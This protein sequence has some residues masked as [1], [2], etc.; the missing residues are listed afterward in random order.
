[1]KKFMASNR[2]VENPNKTTLLIMNNKEEEEVKVKVG[3]LLITQDRTS[4]LL[5]I[6]IDDDMGW[7]SHVYRKGALLPSL[8]QRTHLNRRLRNHIGVDKLRKVADS[9]WASKL[10]YGFQQWTLVRL[11]DTQQ[12]TKQGTDIQKAQ[13]KLLRVMEKKKISD[14]IPVRTMLENQKI[15]SVNQTA[16]Q[17]ILLETWK[18]KNM[19]DYPL[20]IKF[21]TEERE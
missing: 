17:I 5:G 16:A 1:M 13:N 19:A 8:N 9:L 18:A 12:K 3:N 15:V 10:C 14:K 6:N 7:K 4:K 21:Q 2:L 11:E 20:N